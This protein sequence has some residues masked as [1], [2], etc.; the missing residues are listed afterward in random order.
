MLWL[1]TVALVAAQAP[2]SV[3]FYSESY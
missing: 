3:D 2:V 1:L